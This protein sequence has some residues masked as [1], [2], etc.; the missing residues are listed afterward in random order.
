MTE[1]PSTPVDRDVESRTELQ[2]QEMDDGELTT[3]EVLTNLE[4]GLWTA[5]VLIPILFWINGSSVSRDQFVVRTVLVVIA[6]AGAPLMRFCN[7]RRKQGS[8]ADANK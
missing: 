1:D 6:Y 5:V 4:F 8:N 7:Y 2:H 3:D